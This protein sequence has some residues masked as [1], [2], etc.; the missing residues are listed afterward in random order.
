MI[1]EF[2]D[3]KAGDRFSYG[4]DTE[5]YTVVRT[6]IDEC[7]NEAIDTE[8]GLGWTYN[9][10][11]DKFHWIKDN[12]PFYDEPCDKEC[13]IMDYEAEFNRLL[14]DY[15][16]QETIINALIFFIENQ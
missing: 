3:I 1:K 15:Q 9:G 2:K 12:I 6:S 11:E 13:A 4:D 16:K 5:V 7:N 10:Y 8:G 14:V